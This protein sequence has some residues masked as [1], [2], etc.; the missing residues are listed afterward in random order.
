MLPALSTKVW[1]SAGVTLPLATSLEADLEQALQV[2]RPLLVVVSLETCS[3][4]EL[5]R[6]NYLAP[7]RKRDGLHVVQVDMRS[8]LQVVDFGGQ[9]MSHQAWIKKRKVT[10]APTVLFLGAGG[11]EVA[12][13]LVG[14][15]PDFYGAYLEDR[16]RTAAATITR[17]HQKLAV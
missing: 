7:M 15:S 14:A 13:R 5:V 3:Y 1:A 4:C 17:S 11:N 16:L 8:P 9:L 12:T 2:A 6:T 10:T